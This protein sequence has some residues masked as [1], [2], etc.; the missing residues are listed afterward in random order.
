MATKKKTAPKLS[1]AKRRKFNIA[2]AAGSLLAFRQ[3]LRTRIFDGRRYELN[4][5]LPTKIRNV[6]G[7]LIDNPRVKKAIASYKA[8][9]VGDVLLHRVVKDKKLVRVYVRRASG[10]RITTYWKKLS[11][12]DS[13]KLKLLGAVLGVAAVGLVLREVRKRRRKRLEA[14]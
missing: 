9:G 2:F 6:A 11:Q 13:R 5:I 10:T 8:K 7:N 3:I 1:P 14:K 4:A 12:I